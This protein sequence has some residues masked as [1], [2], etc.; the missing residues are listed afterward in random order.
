MFLWRKWKDVNLARLLVFFFLEPW[1]A[2]LG[3]WCCKHL[4][5]RVLFGTGMRTGAPSVKKGDPRGREGKA[6]ESSVGELLN[7]LC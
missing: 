4:A 7:Y 1:A 5:Q 3:M 2:F 6:S